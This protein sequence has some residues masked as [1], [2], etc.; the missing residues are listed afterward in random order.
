MWAIADKPEMVTRIAGRIE[1][2]VGIRHRPGA[3]ILG[4]FSPYIQVSLYG[5]LLRRK[6]VPAGECARIFLGK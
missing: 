6:P 5:G 3:A 2:E 1:D 4:G